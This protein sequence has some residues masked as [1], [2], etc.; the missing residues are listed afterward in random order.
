MGN[1]AGVLIH[2]SSVIPEQSLNSALIAVNKT[3]DSDD[4]HIPPVF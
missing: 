4:R 3:T 2:S 1:I